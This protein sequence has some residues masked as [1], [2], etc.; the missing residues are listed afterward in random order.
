[1]TSPW[2]NARA[3]ALYI[4]RTSKNA[5]KGMHRL[6]MEKKIIAGHDG[7][8]YRFKTQELDAWMYLN[9]EKKTDAK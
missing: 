1:M 8:T 4:G 6:A 7:K 3:A 9:G 5:Y 2:L